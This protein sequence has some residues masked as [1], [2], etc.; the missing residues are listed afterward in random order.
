MTP[1]AIMSVVHVTTEGLRALA[2]ANLVR[3]ADHGAASG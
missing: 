1:I 2:G 3:K